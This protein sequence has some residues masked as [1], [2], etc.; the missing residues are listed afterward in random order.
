MTSKT[1]TSK[2]PSE[3]IE[4]LTKELLETE[5]EKLEEEKATLTVEKG[6]TQ[7]IKADYDMIEVLDHNIRSNIESAV[8]AIPLIKSKKGLQRV[9]T[10]VLES[11]IIDQEDSKVKL[12][13]TFEASIFEIC[14]QVEMDKRALVLKVQEES[15]YEMIRQ[16]QANNEEITEEVVEEIVN[17]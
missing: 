14:N 17:E 1:E 3:T 4:E 9:L 7:E 5:T 8:R 6:E 11:G 12:R 10:R 16:H 15:F 13:D 2:A